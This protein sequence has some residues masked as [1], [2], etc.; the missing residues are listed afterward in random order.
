MGYL[1]LNSAEK[2][3]RL[4]AREEGMRLVLIDF[5]R[6]FKKIGNASLAD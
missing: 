5:L 1:L 4:R 3:G 6:G 2:R